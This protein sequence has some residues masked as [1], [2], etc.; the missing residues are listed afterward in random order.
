MRHGVETSPRATLHKDLRTIVIKV[1]KPAAGPI[2]LLACILLMGRLAFAGGSA[3]ADLSRVNPNDLLALPDLDS[4]ADNYSPSVNCT[5]KG[6]SNPIGELCEKA[7][8]VHDEML[9][10]DRRLLVTRPSAKGTPA[11]AA[12]VFGCV[13]GQ[14]KRLLTSDNLSGLIT[15]EHASRDEVVLRGS[16]T[17]F[18]GNDVDRID[19]VWDPRIRRYR[20]N[21]DNASLIP[22]PPKQMPCKELKT[23]KANDLIILANGDSPGDGSGGYPFIH[24]QGCYESDKVCDWYVEVDD[25]RMISADRRL[26]SFG[27]D[28]RTGT[29]TWG[30]LYVFGCVAGQIRAIYRGDFLQGGGVVEPAAPQTST[31]G[32]TPTRPLKQLYAEVTSSSNGGELGGGFGFRASPAAT[33]TSASTSASRHSQKKADAPTADKLVVSGCAEYPCGVEVLYTYKW[34]AALQNYILADVHYDSN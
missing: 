7:T 20:D 8:I 6:S 29:G 33:P 18:P 34:N 25:D 9:G 15:I 26:I 24:G 22:A 27:S 17:P 11:G 30:Y 5:A 12:Y 16:E 2:A 3:C 19:F 14:A 13:A 31:P 1:V 21:E 10:R 23:A 4:N 28:H 32:E